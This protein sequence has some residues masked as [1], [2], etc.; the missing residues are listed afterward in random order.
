MQNH[1]FNLF[2]V[3]CLLNDSK[4]ANFNSIILS[5]VS[6]LF[7]ESK[8][9][10]KTLTEVYTYLTNYLKIAIDFDYLQNL[11]NQSEYFS[12][13]I[14]VEDP[15]VNLFPEKFKE[16]ENAIVTS[17][18]E[19]YIDEYLKS[20]RHEP[21]YKLVI[22]Q[23]LYNAV[24]E[25]INS[26]SI[27]NLKTLLP[28]TAENEFTKADIDVFNDFLD[29]SDEK[30]NKAIYNVLARA[31]EFA[32]L[33]S[34]KGIKEFTVELF[35]NKVFILDTNI[36]FRLLGVGGE[37]RSDSIK[38]LLEKCKEIG[39]SFEYTSKTHYEL[40]NKLNQVVEFLNKANVQQ[41][42]DTLG[43]IS[44]NH[45]ELLN[46]DF[47]VHYS[48]Y[49]KKNI[50][51]TPEQYQRTLNNEYQNLMRAIGATINN[52]Q[53]NDREVNNLAKLLFAK[54][55]EMAIQYGRKASEVDAYNI[56]LVRKIRA[57]N[58][59]NFSDV[60][61]FYLTSDR[62]LNVIVSKDTPAN[63]PETILP[64]QLY[65]LAKP[66]FADN[67]EDDY[68][69]FIKF[70]KKRKTDFKYAGTQV[71]NYINS[72]REITT[73]VEII[74]DS[75]ILYSDI[76]YGTLKDSEY[77]TQSSIPNYKTIL[78]TILDKELIKGEESQRTVEGI[79]REVTEF[80]D[81]KYKQ[82][83]LIA[84]IIDVIIILGIVPICIVITKSL[85]D[86]TYIIAISV[87]IGEAIKFILSSRLKVFY[88]LHH[89]LYN[90]LTKKRKTSLAS[91]NGDL[92]EIIAAKEKDITNN[93]WSK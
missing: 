53:V 61:S 78:Q 80:A 45:P 70:I 52:E 62:S 42:I 39:M 32:I 54:K 72:V 33:T 12:I 16:V 90:L 18:I 29:F 21:K 25:N 6:E 87:V 31:I 20:S 3:N 49:R 51:K 5:V 15:L 88:N 76:R 84:R 44:E 1:S 58:N 36:I 11:L 57:A 60:K 35:S 73:N 81:K 93:V 68:Q 14:T 8:N 92:V 2:R 82:S 22:E 77:Q 67:N 75:L 56:I 40:Q 79:K 9:E 48:Q 59:Y 41:A 86:N 50:A 24:Y 17:S 26:F 64:S 46:N 34:G 63:I 83:R 23:L 91:I 37:E 28:K 4:S 30:K 47:I 43:A 38:T 7:F 65:I 89:Y 71:L 74:S 27:D 69:E 85:T 66:Y 10:P 19:K 55:K 13:E